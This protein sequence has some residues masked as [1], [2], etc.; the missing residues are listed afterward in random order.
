MGLI[1][2]NCVLVNKWVIGPQAASIVERWFTCG[3]DVE[4]EINPA[5]I[6]AA[7]KIEGTP[8]RQILLDMPGTE[9]RYLV[10]T[11]STYQMLRIFPA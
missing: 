10:V 1:R 8:H 11:E 4:I 9:C 5:Y 7:R 3:M 2:I 6:I